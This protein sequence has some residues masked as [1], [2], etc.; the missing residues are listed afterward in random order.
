MICAIVATVMIGQNV[1]MGR[2]AMFL[3][4][5][6]AFPS[7]SARL[8]IEAGSNLGPGNGFP[9]LAIGGLLNLKPRPVWMFEIP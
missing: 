9:A 8:H 6:G 1:D 7:P 5:L 4:E 3:N 2:P